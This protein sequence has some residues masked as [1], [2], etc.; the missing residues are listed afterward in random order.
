MSKWTTEPPTEPGWYW[1]RW[2]KHFG[3]DIEAL[4]WPD[5]VSADLGGE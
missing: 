4:N 5:K 1:W 2:S 3:S